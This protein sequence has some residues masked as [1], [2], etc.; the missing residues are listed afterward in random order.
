MI[1]AAFSGLL[2]VP[3]RLLFDRA[4]RPKRR[5]K[6]YP[7]SLRDRILGASSLNQIDALLIKGRTM[8]RAAAGTVRSWERAAEFRRLQLASLA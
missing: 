8:D 6:T 4:V 2:K 3:N 5:G 7:I 1:A